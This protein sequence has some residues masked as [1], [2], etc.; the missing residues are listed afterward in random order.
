[1]FGADGE[2]A[3]GE[4]KFF[5]GDDAAVED[6]V[7]VFIDE[8]HKSVRAGALRFGF[9]L[10]GTSGF[11]DEESALVIPTSDDG[12]L[13]EGG[14]GD[15]FELESAWDLEGDSVDGLGSGLGERG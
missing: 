5:G 2:D 15:F 4:A 14:A 3:D 1:M 11:E 13:D 7:V 10:N 12:T 8:T 9:T 6:A